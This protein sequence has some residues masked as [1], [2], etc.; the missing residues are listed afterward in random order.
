MPD[1]LELVLTPYLRRERAVKEAGQALP[2]CQPPSLEM[3]VGKE[4]PALTSD[5][6]SFCST[7]WI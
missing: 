3:S 1:L 4:R 7:R 2:E 6:P 5:Y